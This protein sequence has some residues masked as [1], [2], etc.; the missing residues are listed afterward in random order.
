MLVQEAS[1]LTARGIDQ[2]GDARPISLGIA[3][4]DRGL[5]P[6]SPAVAGNQG[7]PVRRRGACSTLHPAELKGIGPAS[8]QPMLAAINGPSYHP[9][10]CLGVERNSKDREWFAGVLRLIPTVADE[11]RPELGR[12]CLRAK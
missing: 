3:V 7:G 12:L 8:L 10:P 11:L 4:A 1:L 2:L 5:N 6:N 9:V